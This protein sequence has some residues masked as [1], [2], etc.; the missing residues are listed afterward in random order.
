MLKMHCTHSPYGYHSFTT[1]WTVSHP[2]RLHWTQS[3][4][5]SSSYNFRLAHHI[6]S[7][8]FPMPKGMQ[9]ASHQLPP[10][11]PHQHAALTRSPASLLFSQLNNPHC[12]PLSSSSALLSHPSIIYTLSSK[13]SP[14]SFS[15]LQLSLFPVLPLNSMCLGRANRKKICSIK[16]LKAI[17]TGLN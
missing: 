4:T 9:L 15:F 2:P 1:R 14:S 3:M 10:P 12:S 16:E 8:S 5:A 6:Q 7:L 11:N 13:C 17:L